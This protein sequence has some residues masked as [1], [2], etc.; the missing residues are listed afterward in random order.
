MIQLKSSY[1][2]WIG[3]YDMTIVRSRKEISGEFKSRLWYT[4]TD[5]LLF[6]LYILKWDKR[7]MNIPNHL[8]HIQNQDRNVSS[9]VFKK[10]FFYIL[11]HLYSSLCFNY[12]L[13][14]RLVQV[15]FPWCHLTSFPS[16]IIFIWIFKFF[17]EGFINNL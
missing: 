2:R 10:I 4:W 17:Y 6:Y 3:F 7:D 1:Y 8:D 11:I 12:D 9:L 5:N 15:C 14:F 16:T 13:K